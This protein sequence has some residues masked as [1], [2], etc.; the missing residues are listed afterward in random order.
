VSTTT[1][2]HIPTSFEDLF[3]N[4]YRYVVN[5]VIRKGIAP[6]N[7]ED[8]AMTILTTFYEKDVL[9]DYDPEHTVVHQGRARHTKFVTFLSGF[10]LIYLRHHRDRQNIHAAREPALCN[11][12]DFATDGKQEYIEVIAPPTV[13]TY[14]A[15]FMEDLIGVIS[16]H[17]AT[18]RE[19]SWAKVRMQEFFGRV[20]VQ[21]NVEGSV[22]VAALAAEYEVTQASVR[23]W[24]HRLHDEISVALADQ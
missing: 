7:A 17:L 10:V 3:V 9:A 19:S 8:V 2:N 14:D 20:L 5:L 6:Q 21:V 11:A 16:K 18:I 4:Y 13:E 22:D 23:N 12:P 24:L 1:P 15:L